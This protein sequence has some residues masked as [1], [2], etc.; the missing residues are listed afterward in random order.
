MDLG[1]VFL[2]H[3]F[4]LN[5]VPSIHVVCLAMRPVHPAQCSQH[6]YDIKSEVRNQVPPFLI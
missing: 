2:P 1:C 4:L 3:A 5:F 6:I